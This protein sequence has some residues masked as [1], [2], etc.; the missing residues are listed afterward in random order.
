MPKRTTEVG[1]RFDKSQW[2]RGSAWRYLVKRFK[3]TKQNNPFRKDHSKWHWA[4][5]KEEE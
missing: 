4:W 3:I 1:Y 2:S 5:Y